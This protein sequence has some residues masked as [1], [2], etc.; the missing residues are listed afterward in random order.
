[1]PATLGYRSPKADSGTSL[2]A[3]YRRGKEQSSIG[4][5]V[6]VVGCASLL[7]SLWLSLSC[8]CVPELRVEEERE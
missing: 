7:V 3:G 8:E 2:L 1:M 5:R 6:S 4:F